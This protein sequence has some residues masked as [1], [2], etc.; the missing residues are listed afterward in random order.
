MIGPAKARLQR[1]NEEASSLL[2]SPIEE[3]SLEEDEIRV[4]EVIAR[5]STN[6]SLLERCNRDWSNLLKD[7]KSE[8]RNKEEKEYQ[9]VADGSEGY[10]EVMM[11]ANEMVVRL[12]GRLKL[13]VRARERSRAKTLPVSKEPVGSMVDPSVSLTSGGHNLEPSSFSSGELG[14]LN[15]RVNL[16]RLQLPIFDGNIQQWQEFWD[17]FN[18]TIHE[19]QTLSAVSKFNYLKS[20]L[21]GSALSTIVGIPLTND[22]YALAVRLL[23]EKFGQKEA[24]VGV[25]YSKLQNLPKANSKFADIQRTSETIEKLLRQLEAQ[26]ESINEQKILIQQI[27]SKYP[28]EVIVK[29]EETKEPVVPWSVESLRKA[30]VSYI[31]VQ[32]NV[33]RYVSTNNPNV[34]GQD[35]IQ[36]YVS[37]NNPNVRGQSFV[38][39]QTRSTQDSQRPFTETL[40]TNIQRKNAGNQTKASLPCLFCRGCHFNDMC[41]KYTTLAGRK[42]VLNQ[43]RR[44]FI[45]LKV[46]HVSKDCPSSQKKSCCYCGK[47]G[48]HNRCLC[49]QKFTRQV[50]ESF[51]T[52]ES[53]DDA[54][55]ATATHTESVRETDNSVNIVD[56]NTTPMLLASGE[57]VLLQIATV[58][59]QKMDGSVTVTAR[60]L[61]DSASQ[62]TFMTDRL[63]K[64]LKLIPEHKELLSVSTFGAEKASNIDT[65]VVHF[66]VKTKDG[67]HMLMFAN[68]LNQI[69]GNIKRGPLHQKDM[70]FLQ[71]IP[72]NKMADPIPNTV[73]TTAIDLLVGSDYFWDVVGG[74]KIM[75]PSGIFML[76]SKFGYIITGRY[77]GNDLDNQN[78]NASTLL[79]STN[80]N[81]VVSSSFYCSVNVSLIKNPDL[82]R[83][84]SLETIGIKDPMSKESDEEAIEKF[85]ST[86]KF[87]EGRYQVSWPWKLNG[88][89]VSDNFEVAVRRMKSLVRRLQ[90]DAD[91]LQIYDGII[92]QQLNQGIIERVNDDVNQHTKK[93][94]MPHHPV[95]TPKKATT[96][97][98]IVY[99]ASSKAESDMNSLNECL[100][101]GPVILPDLCGLLIRFRMYPVIVLADIEKAFLQVGIQEAE[102]DV[103]RFLWLKDLNKVD[104]KGNLLTYRFCR[105]PFGLVCS[106][107]LLG[108]TIKFHLQKEG[109]PLALHILRNI[110]V[111]NVLIGINSVNEICGVYEEAKSIFERAAMNLRQWNSNCCEFLEF[112]PNCEKAA[113][114]DNTSVLGLSWD[115][116]E[117]MINIS[118]CDKVVTSDVTKRDVLH[119]VAAIFDPLG[120]LS[121]IAFHGKI[122]LQKLWVVDKPWDELLSMKL[123]TE[124]KQV[125]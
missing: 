88:I 74:D 30:I 58:P 105:V 27:I 17:I 90:S 109:S 35:N 70:E 65:Y 112:L 87:E 95:L 119:S 10:I 24:I 118:G 8:E 66:R 22:N 72:Q 4:E 102:R 75:L 29:L 32:E 48:S 79:V 86:I 124:W 81:E 103:T 92:K 98:R 61:L 91:L 19:Q 28:S 12:Q 41:D 125:A 55:D 110:Y 42:Q 25:L 83:F 34:R 5:I 68:V 6:I 14:A 71:L 115:Q 21:K 57:K 67:S 114:S 82:E 60:V 1:Y 46:S 52:T 73:E 111:D 40:V 107:F 85:C 122:F 120:L 116:F 62:R 2:A 99:D 20:V 53:S 23:Q 15:L 80:R 7:L 50:T 63:A 38:S 13:I 37:T 45:C 54:I 9:R 36:H 94:Y 97:V 121:P 89:C 76:P 49:P 56:S 123:L 18:S 26:G 78:K 39:R 69:T 31:A 84:W 100:H 108:A 47:K 113:A 106:P 117:D 11:D 33:Q 77:P 64:Q 3:E 59:I 96:K 16:P 43:Q 44:C 93:Y 104:I 101:R 51:V